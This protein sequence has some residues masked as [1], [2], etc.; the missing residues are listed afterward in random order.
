L[1]APAVVAAHL[2][3]SIEKY[4]ARE[5]IGM[6]F[7]LWKAARLGAVPRL[8]VVVC[9]RLVVCPRV[10]ARLRLR[11]PLALPRPLAMRLP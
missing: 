9:P 10:V 4:H 3:G 11:M 7:C 1:R 2:R 6:P 5:V 8:R